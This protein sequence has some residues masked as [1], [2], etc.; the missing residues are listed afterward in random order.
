VFPEAARQAQSELTPT[1]PGQ[2]DVDTPLTSQVKKQRTVHFDVD[3][4]DDE[5]NLADAETTSVSAF[6]AD[7]DDSSLYVTHRQSEDNSMYAT[8]DVAVLPRDIYQVKVLNCVE[9]SDDTPDHFR[10]G[11][12][13]YG[14]M[15]ASLYDQSEEGLNV[16][17]EMLD[18]LVDG[19][20]IGDGGDASEV[21]DDGEREVEENGLCVDER[22]IEEGVRKGFGT[23]PATNGHVEGNEAREGCQGDEEKS[24]TN[25][26]D[27]PQDVDMI[28]GGELAGEG[29][30]CGQADE[31][32]FMSDYEK[33]P[34]LLT[35][36][37]AL[38]DHHDPSAACCVATQDLDND[39]AMETSPCL[40]VDAAGS[41]EEVMQCPP[42]P[43]EGTAAAGDHPAIESG[44]LDSAAS[45]P[46]DDDDD[47]D[48][49]N[50][51]I[52]GEIVQSGN[53]GPNSVAQV[54][55][56]TCALPES[57]E[58]S[59]C[60]SSEVI[61]YTVPTLKKVASLS[62][63]QGD[64]DDQPFSTSSPKTQKTF[65]QV[66]SQVEE[67][68]ALNSCD[69]EDEG[70]EEIVDEMMEDQHDVEKE[71]GMGHGPTNVDDGL[72]RVTEVGTELSSDASPEK[73]HLLSLSASGECLEA[74]VGECQ[75]SA[76]EMAAVAEQL[77]TMAA[78]ELESLEQEQDYGHGEELSDM[79][80]RYA[81]TM[82]M[83]V[84]QTST[85]STDSPTKPADS[86]CQ[87]THP[88]QPASAEGDTAQ[89]YADNDGADDDCQ[90]PPSPAH[91]DPVVVVGELIPVH[92]E[93]DAG[94]E[95]LH[96]AK[97]SHGPLDVSN[98]PLPYSSDTS[99]DPANVS[100]EDVDDP[101]QDA[102]TDD[103]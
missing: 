53:V 45:C 90:P 33:D 89:Q 60:N 18:S 100:S 81:D 43:R 38:S 88:S 41:E 79:I 48:N 61:V 40:A 58:D 19:V 49:N 76:A 52:A 32:E 46:R 8:P 71:E 34:E 25:T 59:P 20:C 31:E 64:F 98:I 27:S 77:E 4:D 75:L 10:D 68:A 63:P 80:H 36:N 66:D 97:S 15:V 16:V 12:I 6:S 67:A 5:G 94:D 74:M 28:V 22:E 9:S 3:D 56:S 92:G 21:Y 44:V 82:D 87:A 73:Q 39:V 85:S 95:S 50:F 55:P 26:G 24:V 84:E 2:S 86:P 99:L 72:H 29:Y 101:T 102:H 7:T 78:Q 70:I 11:R 47:Y 1:E 30:G 91:H 83:Q 103:A 93:V 54:D 57:A 69:D 62:L 23:K 17:C 96:D 35:T 14:A 13:V 37:G 42:S 51:V 65:D